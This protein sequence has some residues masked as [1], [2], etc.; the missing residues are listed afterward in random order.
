MLSFLLIIETL[1]SNGPQLKTSLNTCVQ[2]VSWLSK[3]TCHQTWDQWQTLTR[4]K[5]I[6]DSLGCLVLMGYECGYTSCPNTHKQ[7]R[8]K[9]SKECA[10]V[11]SGECYGSNLRCLNFLVQ[12]P[13]WL[14]TFPWDQTDMVV[15][16][17][18]LF[19]CQLICR[20]S[21]PFKGDACSMSK[22]HK[23][24]PCWECLHPP[25]TQKSMT[26]LLFTLIH[27]LFY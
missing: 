3:V 5:E 26:T 25:G 17:W 14:K 2:S 11:F 19:L 6:T 13:T 10:G 8:S 4:P 27:F 7:I 16:Q 15:A 12:Q 1:P 18:L 9:C 23:R 20:C 21:F 24:K 22:R